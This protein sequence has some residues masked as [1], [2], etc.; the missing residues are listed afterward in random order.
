MSYDFILFN[1]SDVPLNPKKFGADSIE[2]KLSSE[3]LRTQIHS[4]YETTWYGIVENFCWGQ[5]FDSED[6]CNEFKIHGGEIEQGHFSVDGT[7]HIVTKLSK[8][9]TF[10]I[11][12]SQVSIIY[13]PSGKKIA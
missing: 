1:K 5:H 6:R 3:N 8:T 7:W 10:W 2:P 4:I 13:D 9:L 11:Y 12:D